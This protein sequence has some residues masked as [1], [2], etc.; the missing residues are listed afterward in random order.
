MKIE[1]ACAVEQGRR[2]YND[3]RVL[4]GGNVVNHGTTKFT[5]TA[6]EVAA[7]CDGCGGYSGGY[8]AA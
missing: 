3:D 4:I 5:G 6:P 7:V 8:M 2:D 1:F